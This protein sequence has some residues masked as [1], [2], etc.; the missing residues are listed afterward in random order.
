MQRLRGRFSV[1]QRTLLAI[2]AV[3]GIGAALYEGLS[4]WQ[5]AVILIALTAWTWP[6]GAVAVWIAR[7]YDRTG[8][9]SD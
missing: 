2:A 1:H 5:I 9:A 6:I 8:E 3:L 4:L 7:G